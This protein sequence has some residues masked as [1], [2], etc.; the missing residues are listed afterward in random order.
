MLTFMIVRSLIY[1]DVQHLLAS[2][3]ILDTI[4]KICVTHT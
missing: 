2:V 1:M 3:I 4:N